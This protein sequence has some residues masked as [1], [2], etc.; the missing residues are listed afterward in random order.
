MLSTLSVTLYVVVSG[1]YLLAE[2]SGNLNKKT[3]ITSPFFPPGKYC[4][5]FYYHMFGRDMG[6]M[7]MKLLLD[8]TRK[9][10]WEQHGDQSDKWMREQIQLS[11]SVH[12]NFTIQVCW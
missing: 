2:A 9:T 5:E 8:G 11:D 10:I 4:I 3:K 12:K 1:Y 7:W 6:R